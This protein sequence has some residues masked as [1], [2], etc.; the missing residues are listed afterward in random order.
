MTGQGS[1]RKGGQQKT[2]I[3]TASGRAFSVGKRGGSED[4]GSAYYTALTRK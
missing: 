1:A 4:G 2:L 3:K